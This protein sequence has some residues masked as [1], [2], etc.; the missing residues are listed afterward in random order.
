MNL[1]RDNARKTYS[2]AD[3]GDH[4]REGR[5]QLLTAAL[6]LCRLRVLATPSLPPNTLPGLGQRHE[7]ICGSGV[8]V[9]LP[10]VTLKVSLTCLFITHLLL[11]QSMAAVSFK[12]ALHSHTYLLLPYTGLTTCLLRHL[13]I[14]F[15][16]NLFLFLSD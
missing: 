1:R 16:S 13:F 10:E 8:D 6:I 11:G 4:L 14:N 2:L 5:H 15:Y 3:V 7:H 9:V 12:A